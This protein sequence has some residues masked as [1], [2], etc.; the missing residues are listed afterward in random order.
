MSKIKFH[1]GDIFIVLML[2]WA[3]MDLFK[4]WDY[5]TKCDYSIAQFIIISMILIV[6]IRTY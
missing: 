6:C 4:N 2:C 3:V 1:C 5:Y